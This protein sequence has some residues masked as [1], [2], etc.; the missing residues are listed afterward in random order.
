MLSQTFFNNPIKLKRCTGLTIDQFNELTRRIEPLWNK[1]ENRRL[2][3]PDRKRAIGAGHPY[4]LQTIKEK[5]LCIL[6]WYKIY[7]AFWLLGMILGFDAGNACKLVNR[8]RP[9][10]KKAADPNLGIYF[11]KTTRAIKRGRK[12]I[13]SW[14]DLQRKFPEIAEISVDVTEQ[15]RLR[16]KK[17]VQKRYY[18]GKKKRHTLKTQV[19]VSS[20]GK[21][22]DIS[23][24]Y[25]GRIHDYE[26]F[27]REKTP[28]R[29]PKEAKSYLDRG[30][31]GVNR[32]Y[33]NHNFLVPVKRN[34]WKRQLTLSE[35]IKN[36]KLAKKRVIVEHI[37]SKFKKYR[38][39][40][41]VFRSRINH[42]NQDFK[43]IAALVNFRLAFAT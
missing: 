33:P 42:Y 8:L 22:M 3:R 7:P 19:V 20:S 6:L 38:I 27:R 21:V 5:L 32:D 37:L 29:I 39:L 40:S 14:E 12:K 43:N 30:Y 4:H 9:L 28:D 10:V 31:A 2:F 26:I 16:P 35:K 24:S 18:S 41:E 17:Q 36:T 1:T 11:K 13:S 25:P 23:P 34:R 15:Q